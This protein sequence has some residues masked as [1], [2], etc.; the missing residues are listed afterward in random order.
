[1]AKLGDGQTQSIVGPLSRDYGKSKHSTFVAQKVYLLLLLTLIVLSQ[2]P[3]EKAD[4]ASPMPHSYALKM[5]S[6]SRGGLLAD[7]PRW[8]TSLKR[9]QALL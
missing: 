4:S 8:G 1:M 5:T 6:V 7:L 2:Y 3:L 9:T